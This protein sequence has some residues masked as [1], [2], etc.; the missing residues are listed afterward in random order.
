VTS[1]GHRDRI[2]DQFTRQATPFN[3]APTITDENALKLL[4]A[5]SR[6]GIADKVLDVA[7]GGGIVVCAFAPH[8]AHAT[9][10]DL[11]PAMLDHAHNLATREQLS[12]VTW[13]HGDVTA[14]PYP[15]NSFS[16]V[17]TRFSLH[18]LVNPVATLKDMV[19]VCSSGGR[20]I[21]AD[22]YASENA[23][24]AAQ[25]NQLER[26]RDPSHV[27]CLSLP[28]LQQLFTKVGLPSPKVEFYELTDSV[29]A[30]L[31]RSFPN[32]GD[33]DKIKQMFG[34]AVVDDSLGI[35]VERDGDELRYHYPVAILSAVRRV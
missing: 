8:V 4:V 11:T 24:K 25:W 3:T 31:S 29:D 22:M 15:D 27:R 33:D 7:C 9:G 2:V 12:N 14:L 23:S 18:H 13:H 35:A 28:E 34:K 1:T 20:I 26:L 32:P 19:R 30:L 5:A 6:P 10:I 21:V 17:V 16:I